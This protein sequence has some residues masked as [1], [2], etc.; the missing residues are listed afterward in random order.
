MVRSYSAN[1]KT[2]HSTITNGGVK[3]TEVAHLAGVFDVAGSIKLAVYK[4]ESYK[5][6]HSMQARVRIR[7]PV[8]DDILIG[9][10]M[11]CAEENG[12]RYGISE[13]RSEEPERIEFAVKRPESVKR[14]IE[15]LLPYLVVKFEKGMVLAEEVI[16]RMKNKQH[17]NKTGFLEL[18]DFVEDFYSGAREPKYTR[19][20]FESLW[21][22][23]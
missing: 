12:V 6:N 15:P 9:K 21:S 7:R 2:K 13:I 22:V 16:P 14:F 4:D 19:E 11:D 17:T 23:E 1:P 8:D 10:L 18:M 20:Y 3:D 5:I